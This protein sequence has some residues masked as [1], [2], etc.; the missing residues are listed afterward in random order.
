MLGRNM[1]SFMSINFFGWLVPVSS[2][3][4]TM[5][6]SNLRWRDCKDTLQDWMLR[7]VLWV[8]CTQYLESF[9]VAEP[10]VSGRILT[11]SPSSEI[12][13]GSGARIGWPWLLVF[14]TYRNADGKAHKVKMGMYED[15]DRWILS[16]VCREVDSYLIY[17]FPLWYFKQSITDNHREF[18]GRF[19]VSKAIDFEGWSE[20]RV[21]VYFPRFVADEDPRVH[22]NHCIV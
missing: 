22:C 11:G 10:G 20:G 3:C 14:W 15:I 17:I 8:A 12:D 5:Y 4:A 9:Q 6:L 13:S 2:L 16:C 1:S 21:S 19:L 7:W 18:V